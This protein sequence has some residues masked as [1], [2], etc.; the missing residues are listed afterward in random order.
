M[1]S[2]SDAMRGDAGARAGGDGPIASPDGWVLSISAATTAAAGGS[3]GVLFFF[4]LLF[5]FF[6][7]G[8]CCSSW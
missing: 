6:F 5:F 8:H 1:Y 4:L 2:S 7:L 3:S